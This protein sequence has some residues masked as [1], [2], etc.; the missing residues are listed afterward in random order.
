[1][2]GWNKLGRRLGL[3]LCVGMFFGAALASGETLKPELHPV[4]VCAGQDRIMV[5][6]NRGSIWTWG[7]ST[8][9][10]YGQMG[11]G[12]DTELNYLDGR[13]TSG[14]AWHLQ[15]Q[16]V[17]GGF[18]VLACGDKSTAAIKRD[19]GLWA[20]GEGLIGDGTGAGEE[21]AAHY[22]PVLIGEGYAQV[23]LGDDYTLAIKRDGSLWAWGGNEYGQLGD[24]SKAARAKPVRVGTGFVKIAAGRTHSAALKA[25]GSL[26]MWGSNNRGQLGMGKPGV[27]GVAAEQLSPVQVGSDFIAV[28][29]GDTY[30]AAIKTNGDLLAWGHSRHGFGRGVEED[31]SP[32][33]QKIGADFISVVMDH[34]HSL[35]L[36]RDGALWEWGWRT[37]GNRNLSLIRL[38]EGYAFIAAGGFESAAI[39]DDGTLWLWGGSNW[40]YL[41]DRKGYPGYMEDKDLQYLFS[42][43]KVAFPLVGKGT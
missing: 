25:D 4:Q 11:L 30:S 35:A 37:K 18:N 42:P 29:V 33:P 8:G 17:A 16:K 36:K 5:L 21:S 10:D 26:W 12:D 7:G 31:G 22:F 39:K 24:G 32:T 23:A 28:A 13:R 3:F 19:G 40:Q 14:G 43:T 38:G 2:Q 9:N 1:M 15:A 6:D 34:S 27:D 41:A 20:W